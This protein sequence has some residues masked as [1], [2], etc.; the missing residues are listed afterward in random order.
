MDG[1]ESFVNIDILLLQLVLQSRELSQKKNAINQQ[2]ELCKANIAQKKSYIETTT[3]SI[4]KLEDEINQKQKIVKHFKANAKSMKATNNYLQQYEKVLQL[5]LE[6]TQENCNQEK[7]V[8]QERIE[9]YKKVFQKYKEYYCESPLAKKLLMIQSENEEIERRI[10]A[11]DGQIRMR[12]K[13]LEDQHGKTHSTFSIENSAESVSDRV[14]TEEPN[15]QPDH[16][17]DDLDA[18]IHLSSLHL[19]QPKGQ[20]GCQDIGEGMAEENL[21]ETI[22]LNTPAYPPSEGVASPEMWSNKEVIEQLQPSVEVSSMDRNQGSVL[23][24]QDEPPTLASIAEETEVVG[25][26]E[27]VDEEQAPFRHMIEEEEQ[28]EKKQSSLT[29]MACTQSSPSRAFTSQGSPSREGP[30]ISPRRM[31]AVSNTPT[32][33]LVSSPSSSPGHQ[34]SGDATSPGFLFSMS[35]ATPGFSGFDCGFN[36][37]SPQ[38]EDSPFTFTSSYFSDKKPSGSKSTSGFP[39]DQSEKSEDDFEFAFSDQSPGNQETGGAVDALPF[40]FNF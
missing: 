33:S 24:V 22:S 39:F 38:A 2:I 19:T 36:M 17:A 40:S 11:C 13:E 15:R 8:Y 6:R 3:C 18:H 29:L 26:R 32:F 23:D 14:S 12:E 9:S 5:E 21:E 30:H 20:D 16:Q 7:K 10:K 35:S 4:R 1:Q 25:Q 27:T 34:E 28:G 31:K 37:A